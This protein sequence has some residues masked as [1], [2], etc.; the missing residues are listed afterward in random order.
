MQL[1]TPGLGL[2]FW[3]TV[4]FSI[5]LFLLSKF[6][7]KPILKALKEREDS[8]DSA[9]S[10]AKK[11]KEDLENLQSDNQRLLDEARAEREKLTREAQATA[12]A[13]IQKAKDAASEEG[14][15]ELN[16]AKVAIQLEKQAALK[17]IEILAGSLSLQIAEKLLRKN[18]DNKEA[19]EALIKQYLNEVN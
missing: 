16:A 19:Q 1:I 17:E 14:A 10:A 11:A 4:T 9:L 8:I 12:Q 7:W 3:M 15:K 5:V 6:A 2:I 18:L 13:I